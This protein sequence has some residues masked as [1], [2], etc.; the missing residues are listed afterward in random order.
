M[1]RLPVVLSDS[2]GAGIM[3]FPTLLNYDA[4]LDIPLTG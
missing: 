4:A 2:G 3:M 1:M